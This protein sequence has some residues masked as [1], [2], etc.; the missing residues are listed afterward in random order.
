VIRT[1]ALSFAWEG[2]EHAGPVRI[3]GNLPYNVASPIIWEL[4]S[5]CPWFVRAVFMIQRE[6]AERLCARPA[7]GPTAGSRPG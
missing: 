3:I 5:H 7:P 1:D 6:V 4:V 2:L